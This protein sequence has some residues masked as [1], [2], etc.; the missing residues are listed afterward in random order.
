MP[1]TRTQYLLTYGLIASTGIEYFYRS[2]EFGILLFIIAGAIVL[3]Q[4]VATTVRPLRIIVAFFLLELLQALFFN[5]FVVTSILSLLVKLF[6]VYFIVQI[7]GIRLIK[8]YTDV[9]YVSAILALVV[10]V[11]TF[12]PPIESFLIEGVAE[13]FFKPFFSLGKSMYE[14]S[15][16]III[17]TFNPYAR[18]TIIRN[19]GPFWEPGAYS[20]FLCL[21]LI[22]NIAQRKTLLNRQNNLFILSIITTFST[23]GYVT[24][25]I[26]LMGYVLT[27]S[28]I[29]QWVK[30]CYMM[31]LLFGSVAVYDEFDF[32]GQKIKEN[33]SIAR[34]DNTSRFGSAYMDIIDIAKNP[35]LGYGRRSENR[36]GRLAGSLD[37]SIHRNNGVTFLAATYGIPAA[38]LY[39]I[40]L[41]AFVLRYCRLVGFPKRFAIFAFLAIMSAGFS[42]GIFDR[43]LLLAFLFLADRLQYAEQSALRQKRPDDPPLAPVSASATH[44]NG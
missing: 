8:Y 16:N 39:F 27:T 36:F 19:S 31:I 15:P 40:I 25:F 5:N 10:Y 12:I 23:A 18:E 2:Q 14:T 43:S 28:T 13:V 3:T 26:I 33:I 41:Y 9:M 37:P 11:L 32:L 35:L 34:E 4:N 1:S 6:M 38:I 29:R 44:I 17:Y 21:A 24:L 22:F 7:C 30:V 20:V 42:Q